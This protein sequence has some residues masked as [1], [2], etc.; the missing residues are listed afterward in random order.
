M[1]PKKPTKAALFQTLLQGCKDGDLTKVTDA[2]TAGADVNKKD[3]EEKHSAVAIVKPNNNRLPL[4]PRHL[5]FHP[6]TA[7]PR[8]H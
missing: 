1:P 7:Q 8:H 3:P 4:P 5:E 2:V 6:T